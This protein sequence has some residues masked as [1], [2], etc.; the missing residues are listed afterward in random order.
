MKSLFDVDGCDWAG[1]LIRAQQ[2]C[3]AA[4]ESVCLEADAICHVVQAWVL[5]DTNGS[6]A[7]EPFCAEDSSRPLEILCGAGQ[8]QEVLLSNCTSTD[9]VEE[10]SA[11]IAAQCPVYAAYESSMA[12]WEDN[13]TVEGAG[14]CQ[15]IQ[16]CRYDDVGVRC[17]PDPGLTPF[18][19]MPA[20]CAMRAPLV[21]NTLCLRRTS[22]NSCSGDC[23]WE[24]VESCDSGIAASVGQCQLR[25]GVY[26]SLIEQATENAD[27]AVLA[28][29]SDAVELCPAAQNEQECEDITITTTTTSGSSVTVTDTVVGYGTRTTSLWRVSP[30]VA[31]AL[32]VTRSR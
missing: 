28:L 22:R 27:M 9:T 20:S 4:S 30:L 29:L 31:M 17:E 26:Y 1:V 2:D 5:N 32:L 24:F 16:G 25:R 3:S 21:Q 14:A 15:A 11:C 23:T 13:C 19:S 18:L 12:S 7:T 8:T 10:I 6:C